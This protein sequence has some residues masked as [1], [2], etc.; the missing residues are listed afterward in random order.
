MM[1]FCAVTT[2]SLV[3][4]A[5]AIGGAGGGE[6]LTLSFG[7][8]SSTP[9]VITH[10]GLETPAVEMQSPELASGDSDQYWPRTQGA[11]AISTPPDAGNDGLWTL[12]M[13]WVELPTDRAWRA[14]I[15][16]PYK[17]LKQPDSTV[18]QIITG[19]NGL[20]LIGSDLA[21]GDQ[22]GKRDIMRVCGKRMPSADYPWREKQDYWA[23]LPAIM[24]NLPA[25]GSTECPSPG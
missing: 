4:P 6:P 10:F 13:Q 25:V 24:Q 7:A 20:L 17:K 2:L 1:R 23:D 16:I 14:A 18:L 21:V 8:Y 19:P 11:N 9:V 3:L 15:E 22:S 5:C 12:E